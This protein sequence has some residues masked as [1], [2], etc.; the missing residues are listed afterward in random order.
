MGWDILP[1]QSENLEGLTKTRL[2]PF[3]AL[4]VEKE[5]SAWHDNKVEEKD[6]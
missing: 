2:L 5:N 1:S 3:Q 6:L 4:L